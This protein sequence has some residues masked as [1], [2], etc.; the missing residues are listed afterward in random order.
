MFISTNLGGNVHDAVL[1]ANT[2]GFAQWV[3]Q[4]V[5]VAG[6]TIVIFRVPSREDQDVLRKYLG[7]TIS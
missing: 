7:Q 6:A 3:F 1:F 2:C 5:P 4:I